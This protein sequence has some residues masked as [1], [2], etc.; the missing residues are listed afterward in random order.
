MEISGCAESN[1]KERGLTSNEYFRGRKDYFHQIICMAGDWNNRTPFELPF[2]AKHRFQFQINL[3]STL[4]PRI[5]TEYGRVRFRVRA[6]VHVE[7][8]G[9]FV[10]DIVKKNIH[11]ASHWRSIE[12]GFV[13]ELPD[14][15][16]INR[17]ME[18]QVKVYGEMPKREYELGEEATINVRIENKRLLPINKI[19]FQLRQIVTFFSMTPRRTSKTVI[20]EVK[21]NHSKMIKWEPGSPILSAVGSLK[22]P[23]YVLASYECCN[24]VVSV[25]Y[26]IKVRPKVKD[27]AEKL[28]AIF[29]PVI[30][31]HPPKQEIPFTPIFPAQGYP[32][33]S[34]S[35]SQ[36]VPQP[37]GAAAMNPNS[38]PSYE[39]LMRSDQTKQNM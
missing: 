36:F 24:D 34:P 30:L 14:A 9:Q 38:L 28:L 7:R 39:D 27:D 10:E 25:S 26:D 37:Y 20:N 32:H 8:S 17:E 15:S 11:I 6:F 13:R 19:K 22:I 16:E 31:G 21:E 4:P 18:D 2:T 33:P 12:P 23:D 29:L 5:S 3:P 1:W 35:T